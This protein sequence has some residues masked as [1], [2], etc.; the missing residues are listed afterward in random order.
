MFYVWKAILSSSSYQLDRC[1]PKIHDTSYGDRFADL[2]GPDEFTQLPSRVIWWLIN[3]RSGYLIFWQGDSCTIE[4]YMP[5]HFARQFD[6]NQLYVG[7]PNTG[8]CFSENLFEG[9]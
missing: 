1:F 2:A 8:I 4:S 7:N 6:Y 5:S 3:I 9:A